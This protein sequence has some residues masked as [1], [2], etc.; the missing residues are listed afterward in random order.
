MPIL[1]IPTT[2]P[3]KS[4]FGKENLFHYFSTPARLLQN[5]ALSQSKPEFDLTNI[6]INS[7]KFAYVSSNFKQ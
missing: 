2:I 3:M 5:I 6:G 4:K 7:Q 1:N